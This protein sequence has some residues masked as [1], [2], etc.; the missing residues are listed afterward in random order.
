MREFKGLVHAVQLDGKGGC[1]TIPNVA[2]AMNMA[3]KE[4]PLWVHMDFSDE[5]SIDWL[6]K[7]NLF[8]TLELESFIADETRPRLSK[9]QKGDMLFVRGV[10]LNPDQSPEDMVAI[11]FFVRDNLLITCRRRLIR[12]V[13]DVLGTLKQQQGPASISALVDEILN[14]LTI[15]MQDVIYALDEQLDVIEEHVEAHAPPY[16]TTTLSQCRRQAISL[17][18]HIRPQKE[19]IWQ[20]GQAKVDWLEDKDRLKLAEIVND[21]TRYIEELETSIERANVL[22][23]SM[24]SQM[25]EQ[26][27][28]RMYVMSVV[29]A[30]F[31]PLGFLT[32]LLGVNIGGIPGTENPFAFILFV[33]FLVVL[34]FGIGVYFRWRKWL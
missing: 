1:I 32:G 2:E 11:R 17:K 34:T 27:N 9:A 7:Q 33:V 5:S 18:R 31:L 15:R 23:Q 24:T 20:L 25:S 26:L 14:R 13:Q 16:D 22:H 8:T 6:S 28:Q 10:N 30:L 4:Q 19:A 21:L 29:A 12:S 3:T